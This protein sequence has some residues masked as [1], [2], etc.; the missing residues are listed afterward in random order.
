MSKHIYL[1]FSTVVLISGTVLVALG[2][3][4]GETWGAMLAGLLLPSPFFKKKE[5]DGEKEG[6]TTKG[7]K[8]PNL[9]F[10]PILFCGTSVFAGNLTDSIIFTPLASPTCPANK[11]CLYT[12]S[13]DGFIYDKDANG[14][15]LKINTAK[16]IRTAINCSGLSSPAVGDMCYDTTS[17]NFRFFSA[18]GWTSGAIDQTQY[19]TKTGIDTITG[20]KTFTGGL[21]SAAIGPSAG[22]QHLLPVVTSDTVALL[23]AS[24]TLT[25]KVIAA[26]SLTIGGA[27]TDAVFYRTCTLTS[28]AAATPVVCLADADVP[29]GKK[30]YL[31]SYTA[32]VNGMT[33]WSM[34]TSCTLQDSAA[35]PF[36]TVP[37][38]NLLA[39]AYLGLF[40]AGVTIDPRVLLGTGGTM[41]KGL[42]IVCNTNGA[43]SDLVFVLQGIIK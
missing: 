23:S 5:K 40:S 34:V 15:E 2:K 7:S 11:G 29:A 26:N 39:N 24:Q 32:Y 14:L 25:N 22:Q 13:A 28:A 35:S 21:I 36:V 10:L 43:G 1:L 41:A 20:Q 6:K 3:I 12:K 8:L 4:S 27:P 9:I 38:A 17:N 16:S 31:T 33:L 19:V 30:A 18:A 42:Q 37:V